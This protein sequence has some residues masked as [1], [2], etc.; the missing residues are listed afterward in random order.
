MDEVKINWINNYE[1]G[2]ERSRREKK[3]LLLDF[4]KEG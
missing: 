2:L 3:P 1:E 4:F